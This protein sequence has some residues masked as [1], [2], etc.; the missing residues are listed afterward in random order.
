M[1]PDSVRPDRRQRQV[2]GAGQARDRV[3][4]DHDVA[5]GLHLALGDLERHLR[6]V[7]VVLGGLVEGRAR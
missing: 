1:P 2:V 6:D 5:A 4:Q 3:E 7:R